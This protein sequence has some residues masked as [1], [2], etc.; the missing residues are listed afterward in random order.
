MKRAWV[1]LGLLLIALPAW[2]AKGKG[3]PKADEPIPYSD[4]EEGEERRELPVRSEPTKVRTEEVE[5]EE[6]ERERHLT[7]TDDPTIGLSAELQ[8]GLMLL[9]SSRGGGVEAHFLW[10][11]R[12]T[13]EWSRRLIADETLREMFFIDFGWAITGA[14]D[15]TALISSRSSYHS[16]T[17]APA[18]GY[19]VFGT[20]IPV[21]PYAQ[22]GL[23]ASLQ[24]TSLTVNG[25]E[26]SLS[27]TKLLVQYG[28]G[29]RFRPAVSSDGGVRISGRVELTRFKRGYMDDTVLGLSVG[30]T[31]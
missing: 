20:R 2:A 7:Y 14:Q 31:F 13:W 8:A 1:L 16:F 3:K 26:T 12:G 6:K 4:E 22:L 17:A 29:L 11:V 30:V 28:F 21:M 10:G 5:V 24:Y 15:G 23:G 27:G 9:E 25:T 19:P 18:V